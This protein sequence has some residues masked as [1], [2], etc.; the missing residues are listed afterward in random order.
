MQKNHNLLVYYLFPLP[1]TI[2]KSSGKWDLKKNL[3][4]TD[5]STPSNLASCLAHSRL[6]INMA[7]IT[8]ELFL[9]LPLTVCS[10]LQRLFVSKRLQCARH[11]ASPWRYKGDPND[12][13][14]LLEASNALNTHQT[15][16]ITS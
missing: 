11:C 12:E 16:G 7:C 1:L 4:F 9:S 8:K 10:F 3:C 5:I 13:G 2:N 14:T 6:Y 15:S